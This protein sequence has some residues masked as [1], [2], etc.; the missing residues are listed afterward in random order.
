MTSK[1]SNHALESIDQNREIQ[2]SIGE[3]SKGIDNYHIDLKLSKAFSSDLKKL[4]SLL[5]SQL[6]TPKPKQWDNSKLLTKFRSSYLDMM[7][8]LVHRVKTDLSA[9]QVCFLQF[10]AIKLILKFVRE[11]LDKEIHEI[12]SRLTELRGLGSSEAL[13]ADQRLFWLKKNYDTVLYNVNKQIFTQ[14][15]KIEDRYLKSIR[16]Q[17][18][19]EKFRF[20]LEAMINP[21]LYTSKLSSF[22]LLLNEYS[23]WSWNSDDLDFIELNDKV[24]KL[25]NKQLKQLNIAPL[26]ELVNE[27]S[28]AEIHDELG[29]LFH[30]Q[31]FLGLARDTKT[32]I[33]EQFSWFEFPENIDALF[34][35]QANI[36]SF[37]ATSKE[38][39][40][41]SRWRK[42]REIKSFERV[43]KKFSKL[44]R[45][46]KILPQLL[47]SHYMLTSVNPVIIENTDPKIICQFISGQSKSNRLPGDIDGENRLSKEHIKS[48]E[49]VKSRIKEQAAKADPADSLQLLHD[50]SRFRQ[51]LKY[52]R[53]AHRA[54]NR[55]NLLSAKDELKLSK[56]AGTL[57]FLPTNS[58]IEESEERIAHHVILK[59]DIRGST[60][61]TDE[62]Q[63]KGLNPAS[64]FSLRFFNP[65]NRILETYGANKVFI[66]GDAI[67]LSFL[68]Y[69]SAPQQWFSVARA[70]GYAKNMLDIV[71]SNNRYSAQQ[72][73]PLLELGVGICY[74]G[75]SPCFLY[76]EDKPLMISSAISQAD[77][78]S[79][80]SW[81]LRELVAKSLFSVD[82]LRVADAETEKGEKGQH[83][84]RY[85]V[86][87]ILIDQSAFKKLGDEISLQSIGMML[88][89]KQHTFHVGQYPDTNG[90]NKDLI[91]REGKVGLWR[92]SQIQEDTDGEESY[93]EVVVNRKVSTLVFEALSEIE[94]ETS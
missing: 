55:I 47:A 77:R 14:L 48:L 66:E 57:Y 86:N 1:T 65:I 63:N 33:S 75:E 20:T 2:L 19:G 34:D 8:V 73:L 36:D 18:L 38:L 26:K 43:L 4:V 58:E 12:T 37:T 74:S 17:F 91:I 3:L 30:S 52:Y 68:E 24:E 64:Y 92:N 62:L 11:K 79:S 16:D 90:R 59:A 6:A 28:A 56:S 31:K 40:F 80:C 21:L 32:S 29:G 78:L 61:V 54:F 35:I 53:F 70:C 69:E 60:I 7:T 42:R 41:K 82:V 84:M 46:E 72:G 83:Y 76:D 67:I 49:S 88:N 23:I 94:I 44:L 25:F 27:D 71:N 87:G 39:D 10:G 50:I 5:V 85:N 81:N 93:Y 15:K 9:D 22:P 45:S 51:H 89:G 13:T